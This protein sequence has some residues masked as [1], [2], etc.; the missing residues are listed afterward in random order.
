M[1]ARVFI[2]LATAGVIVASFSP[3]HAAGDV[4]AGKKVFAKCA[5]C[6]AV[7]P[8]KNKVGPSLYGVF[9]RK[10]GEDPTFKYSDAMKNSGKT[11]DEATLITY[12]EKPQESVKGTKMT[13]AGLPSLEDRV[14]VIAYLKTL[15]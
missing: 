3:A 4:E 7:E 5:A 9:G 10:A 6:H 1:S 2:A 12:L 8:G 13:F 11:W 15:K 14:N